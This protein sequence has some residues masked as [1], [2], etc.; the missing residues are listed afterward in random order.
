MVQK[1]CALA[2]A[3]ALTGCAPDEVPVQQ[4]AAMPDANPVEYPAALWDRGLQGETLLMLRVNE[5]GSV[6]SAYV[7]NS[8]GYPEFDSAAVSGGR[9][10][11]FT[12][13]RR[14]DHSVAMWTQLRVRFAPD[15]TATLSVPVGPDSMP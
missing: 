12:P 2:I 9:R 8:S 5:R 3:V 6:D 10:L 11:R 14:G 15:S 1:I 7:R 13:G 4:P